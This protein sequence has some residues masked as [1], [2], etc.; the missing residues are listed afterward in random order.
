MKSKLAQSMNLL[1][2]LKGQSNDLDSVRM[3]QANEL[4]KMRQDLIQ[5]KQQE[6]SFKQEAEK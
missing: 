6:E 1:Q 2:E 4:L 3:E 5:S